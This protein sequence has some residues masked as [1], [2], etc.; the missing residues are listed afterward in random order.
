[1]KKIVTFSALAALF[2]A[3]S[4]E[5]SD[6][7]DVSTLSQDL[8]LES[9]LH[10]MPAASQHGSTTIKP[11]VDHGGRILPVANAYAI[12]WGN[13][14]AFPADAK[15]GLT[16]FFQGIAGTSYAGLND[17]YMRGGAST[18]A[19]G[20]NMTDTSAPPATSPRTSTIATEAC[21]A[22][23]AN[24]LAPDPKAVYFVFTSNYPKGSVNYC[25]WHSYGTCRGVTIQVAYMPNLAGVNGCNPLG[26]KDLGCNSL[27][28]GTVALANVTSHELQ[29]AVTDATLNA[30]YDVSGYE[31][32][33]K[34]AWTFASC[35]G[36][37]NGS[38]WEL[39]QVWSNKANACVQQ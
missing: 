37:A 9:P 25:A 24:G 23:G 7:E 34:C 17:E 21:K 8:S 35:V 31:N 19:F 10:D 30:W 26:V 6:A 33:D 32:A 18:V 14:S 38:S 1:M 4:S 36:L 27:S 11:L 39:Q 3:C 5:T 28:Q 20:G 2:L 16:S 13:Q 12:W 15:S 29:E 22:I